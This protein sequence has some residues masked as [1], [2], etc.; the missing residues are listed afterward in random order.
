MRY[1]NMVQ[2]FPGS[3]IAGHYRSCKRDYFELEDQTQREPVK[4]AS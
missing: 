1:N 4:V 2:M 3:V